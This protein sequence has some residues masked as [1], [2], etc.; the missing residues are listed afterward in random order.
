GET[1]LE[2]FVRVSVHGR[3]VLAVDVREAAV[4]GREQ[5][6]P[7]IVGDGE[8]A[9]NGRP[10]RLVPTRVPRKRG[11]RVIEPRDVR[12]DARIVDLGAE[13]GHEH[14][15]ATVDGRTDGPP[16]PLAPQRVREDRRDPLRPRRS[17]LRP[18]YPDWSETE[19]GQRSELRAASRRGFQA[20]VD[21]L[22][23]VDEPVHVVV[24]KPFD[25]PDAERKARRLHHRR[26]VGV[27]RR[28]QENQQGGDDPWPPA[29]AAVHLRL[30]VVRKADTAGWEN[31]VSLRR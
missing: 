1:V 12:D 4:E 15:W 27:E 21:A 28:R 3:P 23:L 8:R 2:R 10:G 17:P 6:P 14:G 7:L 25:A 26:G 20:V 22:G 24:P 18:T 31:A 9:A 13:R 29:P 11:P 30:H 19:G 5:P 16:D